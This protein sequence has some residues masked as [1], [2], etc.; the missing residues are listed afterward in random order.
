MSFS[1]SIKEELSRQFPTARHCELAELAAMLNFGGHI[2]QGEDGKVTIGFQAENEAIVR[3]CFT[4]WKKTFNID[5]DMKVTKSLQKLTI[6]FPVAD[7]EDRLGGFWIK[8]GGEDI[9]ISSLLIKNSCCQRAFLRGA[10]LCIG[11]MSDPEKGYHL[12]L[13]CTNERKAK[14]LQNV[15]QGFGI[16]AKIVLRKKYFVV[17]VKEGTG[18]VDLLN[19]MEAHVA[20]MELENLRIVKDMRNFVNRRVNCEAANISKTVQASARQVDDILLIQKKYGFPNLPEHLR[21]MA[22][23]RLLY[24]EGSLKELGEYSSPP[25]GKSGVNHRLRKLSELAN[26][27]REKEE[28]LL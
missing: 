26:K 2:S 4:L 9:P 1:G 24:P 20:L 6:T 14:Q 27:I 8:L 16:D 12:E 7:G 22:E 10:F 25:L 3:K 21:Q 18:I 15:I 11:S 13:V 17:Y 19:V 28:D 23:I 5:T